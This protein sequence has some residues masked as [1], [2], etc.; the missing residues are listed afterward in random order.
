MRTESSNDSI[1]D[2]KTSID[3]YLLPIH[4]MS[5]SIY[6][7]LQ[8]YA[9]GLQC[10]MDHETTRVVHSFMDATTSKYHF[11]RVCYLQ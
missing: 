6:I 2:K 4:D 8:I 5:M 11:F 9:T 3:I 7:N 1:N 10:D